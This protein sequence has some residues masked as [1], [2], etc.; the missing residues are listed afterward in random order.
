VASKIRAAAE[1]EPIRLPGGPLS[2][3]VSAGVASLEPCDDA[4]ALFSRAE[5]ALSRAKAEGRN[6]VEVEGS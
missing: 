3:T 5:R 4:G 2:V 6:R 1:T